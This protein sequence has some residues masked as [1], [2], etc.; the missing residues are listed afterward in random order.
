M[1]LKILQV[2]PCSPKLNGRCHYSLVYPPY[3]VDKVSRWLVLP[4][5][6]FSGQFLCF[7][8]C[9]FSFPIVFRL[10]L[11]SFL[12]LLWFLLFL[13]SLWFL[14][15]SLDALADSL[16]QLFSNC[17]QFFFFY[18]RSTDLGMQIPAL[19][20]SLLL[21]WD[22]GKALSFLDSSLWMDCVGYTASWVCFSTRCHVGSSRGAEAQVEGGNKDI[23]MT[24][25]LVPPPSQC[26]CSR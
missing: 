2:S 19:G 14:K 21:T 22:V 16:P 26:F 5:S 23:L 12:I 20:L 10:C 7:V 4:I 25:V 18:E 9:F 13:C 8:I 6:F 3:C 24:L 15:F 1:I 17:F 11:F